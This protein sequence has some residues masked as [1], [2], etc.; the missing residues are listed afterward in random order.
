MGVDVIDVRAAQCLTERPFADFATSAIHTL[1]DAVADAMIRCGFSTQD[2]RENATVAV[3]G[4][5]AILLDRLVTGD[6]A[7]TDRSASRLIE[8][9]A[10]E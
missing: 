3:S 10:A 9:V 4:L 2:A 5:R 6:V 7:R 1:I 8:Q